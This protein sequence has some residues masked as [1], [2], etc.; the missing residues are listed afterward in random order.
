MEEQILREMLQEMKGFRQD[1]GATN[2]ELASVKK[3]IRSVRDDISET[4][5]RLFI[6]EQSTSKRLDGLNDSMVVMQQAFTDMRRDLHAIKEILAEKVIWQNDNIVIESKEGT[7][8]EG[9]IRHLSR[10]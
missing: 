5:K 9:I 4:N 2:A 6:L 1:L 3:E 10:E 8:I 7:A